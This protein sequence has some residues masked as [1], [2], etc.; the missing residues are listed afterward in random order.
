MKRGIK[1]ATCV[2]GGVLSATWL[3][4]IANG[5][6]EENPYHAIVERNVF[7]LKPPPPPPAAPTVTNTPPPNVKL[8]GITSLLGVK[9]AFFMV[10]PAAQP[11]KPPGKEESF[12]IEEGQ[13]QGVIEV[14][15]IDQK[16]L[17]VRIK[18]DGTESTLALDTSPKLPTGPGGAPGGGPPGLPGGAGGRP[19]M[20]TAGAPTP[21]NAAY[22][23]A[24]AGGSGGRSPIP[25]P[26]QNSAYNPYGAGAGDGLSSLPSRTMR[27]GNGVDPLQMLTQ[28]TQPQAQP[29]PQ[30][31]EMSLEQKVILTEIERQRTQPLVE[32]GLMPPIPPLEMPGMNN[33]NQNGTGTGA[34][35]P[36]VPGRR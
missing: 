20:P 24:M 32:Q 4:V 1:A 16:A 11:G 18:N 10:A 7:D 3:A 25:M 5:A 30:E 17:T 12:I 8:T 35:L 33:Q 19:H 2:L 6:V 22:K 34:N 28:T 26:N 15:E 36:T 31:P 27:T 14:M 13:R 29:P 21:A 23:P 9:R